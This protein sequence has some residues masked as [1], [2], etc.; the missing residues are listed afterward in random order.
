MEE[1]E[2]LPEDGERFLVICQPHGGDDGWGITKMIAD[3]ESPTGQTKVKPGVPEF[4]SR[5]E[6]VD[7]V[8][9][10][11]ESFEDSGFWKY[12]TGESHKER[13][14]RLKKNQIKRQEQLRKNQ[15]DPMAEI[16]PSV[17]IDTDNAHKYNVEYTDEGIVIQDEFNDNSVWVDEDVFPDIVAFYIAKKAED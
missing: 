7:Y 10:N 6:T 11:A 4:D 5:K 13:Q 3:D 16:P 8:K 15:I 12:R 17:T 14:E 9:R 1:I 2:E